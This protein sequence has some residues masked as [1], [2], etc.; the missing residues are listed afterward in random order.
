M[1]DN[2]S[3][4]PK[5]KWANERLLMMD[6]NEKCFS[7][8]VLENNVWFKNYVATIR[9]MPM[10]DGDG[11]MGGCMM[12]WSFVSDPLD[13]WGL[14]ELC[15]CIDFCLQSMVKKIESAI[16]E[17]SGRREKDVIS[18]LDR[19]CHK[20][21]GKISTRVTKASADQ[22]W[23]LFLDFF[24]L[25]KWLPGLSNCHGIHGRNGKPGCVRYYAGFSLSSKGT[26]NTSENRPISWSKEQ[27]VSVNPLGR[28][29]SYEMV[30]SNIEFTSYV[31]IVDIVPSDGDSERGCM[32]EWSFA[33]DQVQGWMSEDL[34]RKYEVGLQG[35]AKKMEDSFGN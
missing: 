10:N 3:T 6:P 12:E 26:S 23:P 33:I 5:L 20:W 14:Q 15:S 13:G 9:V 32:I 31:S 19:L 30:D 35:M 24:N 16:Q 25:H 2:D 7:Y 34:V 1:I 22:I 28:N 4:P 21:E 11:K 29:L 8:E 17:A 27:L 18:L